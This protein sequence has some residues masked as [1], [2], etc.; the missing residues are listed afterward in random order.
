MAD[1]RAGLLAAGL[2]EQE[3]T[4]YLVY[5]S[6]FYGNMG[7]YKGFGDSKFVPN[8][9][10]ERM[11]LLVKSS[12][13]YKSSPELMETLWQ[14]VKTPM[15]SLSDKEKQLGLGENISDENNILKQKYL[16]SFLPLSRLYSRIATEPKE[17]K[18]KDLRLAYSQWEL[19]G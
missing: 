8:M 15:F 9:K 1:L 6:G 14:S 5:C 17:P 10:P 11:E 19:A 12:Q 18:I 13:A 3:V 7:N 16:L 4:A 2:T